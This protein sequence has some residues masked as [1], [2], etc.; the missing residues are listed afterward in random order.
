MVTLGY[1]SCVYNSSEKISKKEIQ[2]KLNDSYD[3][4]IL[5]T[6]IDS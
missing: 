4:S 6:T 2:G 5:H 3:N 1:I